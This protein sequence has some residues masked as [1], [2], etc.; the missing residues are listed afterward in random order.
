[1]PRDVCSVLGKHGFCLE[2]LSITLDRR[3]LQGIELVNDESQATHTASK[4]EKYM[5][6]CMTNGHGT[7]RHIDEGLND[8][9]VSSFVL[10][11]LHSSK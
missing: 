6:T 3:V 8:R 11:C 7:N 4:R 9:I 10:A 2:I 5:G 1:M